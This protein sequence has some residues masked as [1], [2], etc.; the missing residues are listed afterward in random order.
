MSAA[1]LA[2]APNF[3][4]FLPHITDEGARALATGF[5]AGAKDFSNFGVAALN[6]TVAKD[7][8]VIGKG[9]V[10][11]GLIGVTG[12]VVVRMIHELRD[13]TVAHNLAR[14]GSPPP[15]PAA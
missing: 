4:L 6:T 7:I 14:S 5:A 13:K 11:I 2:V 12:W 8:V 1:S 3:G 15:P 9:V 10:V